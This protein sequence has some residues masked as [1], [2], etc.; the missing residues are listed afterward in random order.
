MQD[1]YDQIKTHGAFWPESVV[2]MN[3]VKA[4]GSIRIYKNR[5]VILQYSQ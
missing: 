3:N 1:Y 5:C 2:V 4:R